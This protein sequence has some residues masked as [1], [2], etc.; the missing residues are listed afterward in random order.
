MKKALAQNWMGKFGI[1]E[2]EYVGTTKAPLR[3]QQQPGKLLKTQV[4]ATGI[5]HTHGYQGE[6]AQTM[7]SGKKVFLAPNDIIKELHAVAIKYF[8]DGGIQATD[9]ELVRLRESKETIRRALADLENDG[10]ALRT[11]AKGTPLSKLTPAELKRLPTGK[12]RL[13]FWL[14][15]KNA[16]E[17]TVEQEWKMA[18]RT[19]LPEVDKN[20]LPTPSIYKILNIFNFEKPGKAQLKDEQFQQRV[21]RAYES[22]KA[23]FLR[24]IEVDMPC[25]PDVD[26]QCLPTD[27]D[28]PRLPEVDT[29]GG[30]FERIV[31]RIENHHQE[32][33]AA[34]PEDLMMMTF[35]R[36]H[37][38]LCQQFADSGKPTPG[39]KLS[40]PIHK[41]LAQDAPQFLQWLTPARLAP[42]KSAGIL[43]DLL[44]NFRD[45]QRAGR[46]QEELFQADQ[47]RTAEVKKRQAKAYVEEAQ[48]IV[49]EPEKYDAREVNWANE[50]LSQQGAA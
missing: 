20:R 3:I 42:V 9:E 11:D 31:E 10:V 32:Q 28:T 41:A 30:A 38:D 13:Y 34:A 43:P 35:E 40:K 4:W 5:L 26:T 45:A 21:F 2:G 29:P 23:A 27:V 12:T 49:A 16:T 17:A 48:R 25:L 6:V 24:E 47:Q 44:N 39:E 1:E 22:A 33:S 8:K 36:F 50:F 37:F 46:R 19:I 15:P 14:R 18:S 7:R